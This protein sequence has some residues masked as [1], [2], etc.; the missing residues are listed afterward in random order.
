MEDDLKVKN[1]IEEREVFRFYYWHSFI[2]G[3]ILARLV[4]LSG[5]LTQSSSKTGCLSQYSWEKTSQENE[6]PELS[7]L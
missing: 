2:S 7:K 1:V 4:C 6:N 3:H 5:H